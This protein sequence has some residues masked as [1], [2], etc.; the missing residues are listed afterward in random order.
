LGPSFTWQFWWKEWYRPGH[1][2]SKTAFTL[3]KNI[4]SNLL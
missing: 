1:Q 3:L 2:V 4:L